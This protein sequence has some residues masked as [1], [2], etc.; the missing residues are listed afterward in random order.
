MKISLMTVEMQVFLFLKDQNKLLWLDEQKEWRAV[1]GPFGKGSAPPGQYLIKKLV[2]IPDVPENAAYKGP[3]GCWFAPL[4]PAFK[5]DRTGLGIHPDGNVPGT[6]GCIGVNKA[7]SA[8]VMEVL[9]KEVGK[10][11]FVV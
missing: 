3:E 1:S 2:D 11:L 7:D 10:V 4:E 8:A 5:T 9:K 6:L